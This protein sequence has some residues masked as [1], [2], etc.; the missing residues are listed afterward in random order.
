MDLWALLMLRNQKY[1]SIAIV[2]D[3]ESSYY[4]FF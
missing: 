1:L 4:H 3:K 2:S